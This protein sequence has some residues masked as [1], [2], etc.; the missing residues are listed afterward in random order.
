MDIDKTQPSSGT[1]APQESQAP[2]ARGG[3]HARRISVAVVGA[4]A[5]VA[6][7]VGI[8][9]AAGS[10]EEP[11][12]SLPSASA[13]QQPV[14]EEPADTGGDTGS[15]VSGGTSTGVDGGTGDGTDGGI[16]GGTD[17]DATDT[18]ST[19]TPTAPADLDEINRRLNE[20][21]QK[22]DQLP[23]KQELADALRAFADRLD[24]PAT[25]TA[26]APDPDAPDAS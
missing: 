7:S 26:P 16:I 11:A 5:L 23:T 17:P 6:L 8:A 24:A 15:G 9:L 21:D 2:S 22:L 25:P 14:T 13:T 4:A 12:D 18:P 1:P 3:L 20:L 19:P 10:D